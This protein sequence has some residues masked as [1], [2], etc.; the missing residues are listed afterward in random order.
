ACLGGDVPSFEAAHALFRRA[1]RRFGPDLITAA[2]GRE[3]RRLDLPWYRLKIPGEHVQLG[4]GVHGRYMYQALTDGVGS[5]SR[6][7]SQDKFLTN[8][9]LGAAGVPV[10]PMMEVSSEAGA[11]AAAGR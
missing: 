7:M 5:T 8:R 1:A 6:L 2:F 11:V 4:Q 9:M 10:L 3:A